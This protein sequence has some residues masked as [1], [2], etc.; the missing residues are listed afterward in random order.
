[1]HCARRRDRLTAALLN[2]LSL[3]TKELSTLKLALVNHVDVT[4]AIV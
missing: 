2:D 1:M 4:N 3:E